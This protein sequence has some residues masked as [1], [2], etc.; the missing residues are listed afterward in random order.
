MFI[1]S[2]R[3]EA[4]QFSHFSQSVYLCTEKTKFSSNDK[5]S[6]NTNISWEGAFQISLFPTII[7]N[8]D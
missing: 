3:Q 4:G 5:I 2:D 8:I 6:L 7:M 1:S